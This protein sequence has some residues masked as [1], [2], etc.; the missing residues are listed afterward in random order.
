VLAC[1]L[2]KEGSRG[3]R[4][5]GYPSLEG[6]GLPIKFLRQRIA[7][8]F[9][10]NARRRRKYLSFLLITA[11]EKNINNQNIERKIKEK[12]GEIKSSKGLRSCR[13]MRRVI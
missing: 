7:M 10:A 3:L 12:S 8:L 6:L 5:G 2:G 11:R 13:L 4:K 9:R 1:P